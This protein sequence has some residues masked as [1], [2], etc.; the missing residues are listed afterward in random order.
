MCALLSPVE[1]AVVKCSGGY[2]G[3]IAEINIV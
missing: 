2:I 3:N 1:A